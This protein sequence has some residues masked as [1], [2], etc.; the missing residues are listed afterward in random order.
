M[1][2]LFG[3]E[4]TRDEL[5]RRIGDISQLGGVKAVELADGNGRGIRAAE[6]KTG[7]GLNFTVSIDRGL[8]ICAADYCGQSLCWRS[9][10]GDTG[11][12]FYEPE[13]LGWL[14]SFYGG[15]LMTCGLTYFGAPDVDQGQ[16]LGLHGRVSN[17]PAKNVYMDG[18]WD[19]DDYVMWIQGK[20]QETAVFQENLVLTRK[21]WAHLGEKRLFI[22]DVVENIGY[23][24][25]EHMLLYH[26]NGGFPAVDAGTR[27]VAPF[28]KTV[29]RT[30]EAQKA[31]ERFSVFQEPTP[32]FS[33]QVYYHDVAADENGYI[34]SALIN[35]GFNNGQGFGFYIRYRKEQLPVL[36][37]WKMMGEGTYVVG[38]EPGTN[39]A[40]GRS[41]ERQEGQLIF[42]EPGESRFYN[43]EIGVLSGQDEI[44]EFEEKV[45][46]LKPTI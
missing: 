44:A 31:L 38:M 21:I 15:L 45:K 1:A 34:Q 33:E 8:D 40:D 35:K 18:E 26:I 36:I 37:E 22:D 32:G 10:T 14:R 6:F 5:L 12:A 4:Y 16:E 2:K 27:I 9:S 7:S 46:Q 30:E 43:L 19:G 28:L 23:A 41:L 11:P 42:L 3:E 13:G 17:I 39:R 25:T 24:S 29:A 20:V